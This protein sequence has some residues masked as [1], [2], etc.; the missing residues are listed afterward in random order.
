VGRCER[1]ADAEYVGSPLE[2]DEVRPFL[3]ERVSPGGA[4]DGP[5]SWARMFEDDDRALGLGC[6]CSLSMNTVADMTSPTNH[7]LG[8]PIRARLGADRG[9]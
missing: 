3:V 2:A 4:D 7:R 1:E 8:C 9:A 6:D 5:V